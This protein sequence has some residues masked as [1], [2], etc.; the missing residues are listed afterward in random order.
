MANQQIVINKCH[1]GFGLSY[2]GIMK[3]AEKKGM[4]LYPYVD[5]RDKNGSRVKDLF[6]PFTGK[7][8]KN[9]W[10]LIYYFT[11]PLVDGKWPEKEEDNT[12]F[13]EKDIERDDLALVATVKELGE[14][15]NG[16]CAKLEVIEIPDGVKWEIDEYDGMEE[17]N[18][19]HRSWC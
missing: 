15:A 11:K 4:K 17:I 6:V 14:K 12:Y 5:K 1:G 10:L 13:Y 3:Y 19:E 18:E 8:K 2:A 16:N 9:E 7:S